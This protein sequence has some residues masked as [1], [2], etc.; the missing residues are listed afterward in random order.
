MKPPPFAYYRPTS[1]AEATRRLRQDEGAVPL[2]GG[3]SLVPLLNMRLARPTTV[4]DLGAIPGLDGITIDSRGLTL[5]AAVTHSRLESYQWPAGY[6]AWP[7]AI[8]RIGYQAIRHRGTL[9]GSLAHADPAAELP[10]LGVAF[11]ASIELASPTGS[12][13]VVADDFFVGYY[14]TA[15]SRDELVVSVTLP[16][17][18]GVRSGFAEMSRRQ[19]DFALALAAVAT[20]T[21]DGTTQAR[22]VVGGLDVRPR[23]IPEIEA[24]LA[25]GAST[26][27]VTTEAVARHV[28]PADDIHASADYRL[29]V[30]TEMLRR[31]I[32][33]L[34]TTA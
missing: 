15:R 13:S 17:V 28:D 19:G 18:A 9:G 30:G 26:E 1:V 24:A 14:S 20:W 31:A 21:D 25:R 3:Q 29:H 23:R 2:S 33:K 4:V 12:R 32:E 5:G 16:H 11:D 7:E 34:G 22:A 27:D 6:G 10:S 8:A